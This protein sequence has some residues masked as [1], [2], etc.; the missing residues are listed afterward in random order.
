MNA[1]NILMGEYVG[2]CLIEKRDVLKKGC[3]QLKKTAYSTIFVGW[4]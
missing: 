1:L 2:S 4:N 3:Y